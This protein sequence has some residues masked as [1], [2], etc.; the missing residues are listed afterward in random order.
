MTTVTVRL[1]DELDVELHAAAEAEGV[2]AAEFAASA[3][4]AALDA[5]RH[6][7]VMAIA[8]RVLASDAVIVHRLGTA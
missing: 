7:E 2:S 3:V 5:R 4:A 6:A 1:P 8:N